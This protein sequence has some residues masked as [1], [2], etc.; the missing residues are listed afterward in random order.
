MQRC[1]LCLLA[2]GLFFLAPLSHAMNHCPD[3]STISRVQGEYA[4]KSTDGRWEGY[5]AKPRYGR[6]ESSKIKTFQQGRWMQLTNL[7]EALGVIECDYLGNFDDEII[8]FVQVGTAATPKP[9]S[10]N[11]SCHFNPNYPGV[12]CMCSGEAAGCTLS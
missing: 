7:N 10:L 3:I 6:G 2:L 9:E 1:F 12:Q 8:R 11:W 4:W 5:F